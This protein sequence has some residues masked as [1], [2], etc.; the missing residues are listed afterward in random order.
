MFMIACLLLAGLVAAHAADDEGRD[1]APDPDASASDAPASEPASDSQAE[2][3]EADPEGIFE[4]RTVSRW[5][6]RAAT[7]GGNHEWRESFDVP[8]DAALWTFGYDVCGKGTYALQVLDEDETVV[9]D[10]RRLF[11]G[12]FR[13]SEPWTEDTSPDAV[14]ESAEAGTYTITIQVLGDIAFLLE[15]IDYDFVPAEAPPDEAGATADADKVAKEDHDHD[16]A[17]GHDHEESD[18]EEEDCPL[19]LLGGRGNNAE[20]TEND[21]DAEA[22]ADEEPR[23]NRERRTLAD[24]SVGPVGVTVRFG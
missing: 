12:C 4:P 18:A 13:L 22:P 21:E 23:P 19:P 16:D 2:A 6:A 15:V 5:E 20:D 9:F 11:H 17:H 3:P 24:A 1:A 10:D 8:A 7:L 14:H